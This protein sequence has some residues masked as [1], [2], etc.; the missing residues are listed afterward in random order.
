MEKKYLML[1]NWVDART[2]MYLRFR[3]LIEAADAL[4]RQAALLDDRLR[5][6]EQLS[7]QEVE[8]FV[9]QQAKNL[10][11]TSANEISLMDSLS[12]LI[13]ECGYEMV[14]KCLKTYEE[15]QRRGKAN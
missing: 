4:Y 5:L 1:R 14:I 3:E 10:M 7:E 15:E 2:V 8:Q 13:E 11:K 6:G 12:V 9:E